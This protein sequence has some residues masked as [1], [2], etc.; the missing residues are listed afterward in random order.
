MLTEAGCTV[1]GGGLAGAH[2]A[3][4]ASMMKQP[5]KI[6][7]RNV[8]PPLPAGHCSLLRRAR[9][10]NRSWCGMSWQAERM[11]VVAR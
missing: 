7:R 5:G 3:T 10:E 11:L 1:G 2:P 6:D 9:E 8:L 4:P